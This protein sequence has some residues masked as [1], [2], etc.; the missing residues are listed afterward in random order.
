MLLCSQ[1]VIIIKQ[2]TLRSTILISWQRH[3]LGSVRCA[4][5]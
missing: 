1:D 2:L 4:W 5:V 3:L